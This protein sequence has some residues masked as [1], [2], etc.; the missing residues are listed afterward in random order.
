[1]SAVVF[2]VSNRPRDKRRSGTV[3]ADRTMRSGSG[4]VCRAEGNSEFLGVAPACPAG[5]NAAVLE[6]Q[7]KFI[8]YAGRGFHHQLCS[9][10]GEIADHAVEGGISAWQNDAR[11]LE[12]AR[13]WVSSA[14]IHGRSSCPF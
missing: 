6:P 4:G 8:R 2:G 3:R 5:A 1:M 12:R 13:A 9:A 7:V 10:L 14:F 11:R